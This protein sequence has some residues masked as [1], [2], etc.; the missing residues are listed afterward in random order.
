MTESN[1][2]FPHPTYRN[3]QRAMMDFVTENMRKKDIALIH[4]AAGV[5][6]TACALAAALSTLGEEKIVCLTRTKGQRDIFV[7]EMRRIQQDM[8]ISY[9]E[10]Q[11][12]KDLCAIDKVQDLTYHDFL[13]YCRD[14]RER[15]ECKYY[16][17]SY[18][19]QNP[20]K[21]LKQ[22]VQMVHPRGRESHIKKAGKKKGVCPYELAKALLKK[23]RV[24]ICS[25]HYL[26]NPYIQSHFLHWM[27]VELDDLKLIVDEA[28]NLPQMI[29]DM[30][31][32]TLSTDRSLENAIED[33]EGLEESYQY[34]ETIDSF[35]KDFRWW[36]NQKARDIDAKKNPHSPHV[37]PKQELSAYLER[38]IPDLPDPE[39]LIE[40]GE[41]I[42]SLGESRSGIATVGRFIDQFR[43]VQD[44]ETYVLSLTHNTYHGTSYNLLELSLIDP[45]EKASTLFN[46]VTSA[47]L[48][49]GSLKPFEY[50]KT[51]LGLGN[52]VRTAIFGEKFHRNRR[53]ILYNTQVSSKYEKRNNPRNIQRYHKIIDAIIHNCPPSNGIL[54]VF[55]SYQFMNRFRNTLQTSRP[56]F[57]ESRNENNIRQKAVEKLE[58][59]PST[60]VM[61]V[62]R[63]K[64]TEGVELRSN[65]KT[66][67]SAVVFV[68]LPYPHSDQITK[69]KQ[70][71]FKKK[72]GEQQAFFLTV[73]A[74]MMRAIL[75]AGGRLIRDRKDYG[76]I[77]ILDSRYKY[78]KK[79][80]PKDWKDAVKTSNIHWLTKTVANFFE[81]K[82]NKNIP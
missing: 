56:I 11:S 66:L 9:S 6:K 65:K 59:E 77:A 45:S 1:N 54:L 55:P 41:D 43:D 20:S 50:Y 10:I 4:G 7:E 25:Y 35:L 38:W 17:R 51:M 18:F 37:L 48:M 2:F 30:Y 33:V 80:F 81:Q 73:T 34:R 69:Y 39:H 67:I 23:A 70:D 13:D 28:H 44:E 58:N 8:T 27:G 68:G 24:I 76:I 46:S 22:A 16:N 64:L 47:V 74:P 63:G 62:A 78:C 53:R 15:K 49:S 12:K 29:A 61:S 32:R 82:Q 79:K 42:R 19:G 71:Y 3:G 75:Q 52:N 5:G 21:H 57:I 31:T 14:K 36:I 60:V 40:L 26:F 72:Y